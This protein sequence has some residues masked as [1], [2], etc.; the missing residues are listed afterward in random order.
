MQHALGQALYVEGNFT[1]WHDYLHVSA[2]TL[3]KFQ[4]Y[5]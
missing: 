4:C 1:M 5:S 2:F 3:K